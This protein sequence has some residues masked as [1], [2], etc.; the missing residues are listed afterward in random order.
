MADTVRTISALQTIL[1]D[2]GAKD[3]TAQNLRDF[4]VSAVNRLDDAGSLPLGAEI[5]VTG[6]TTATLNGS[7]VCS[8]SGSPA[9]YALTLPTAS[10]NAGARVWIRM[11]NGLTKIVTVT[12]HSAELINGQNTRP[13]HSG[14]ACELKCDGTGWVKVS[15]RSIPFACRVGRISLVSGD[16]GNNSL[17]LI[18]CDL[19]YSDDSG[20]MADIYGG[21]GG[22]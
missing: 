18:E 9:D 5:A 17:D 7:H 12:G 1:A 8:D 13:M 14:E 4:L 20:L 19:V 11:A 21:H 16:I 15:G 22:Y 10:G 3:I 2:N 6:A